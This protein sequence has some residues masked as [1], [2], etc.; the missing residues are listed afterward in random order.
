MRPGKSV[1]PACDVMSRNGIELNALK[2][3][4]VGE[5]APCKSISVCDHDFGDE[6]WLYNVLNDTILAK[7]G[8]PHYDSCNI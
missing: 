2:A 3:F 8:Q 5:E 6:D 4:S 7:S 1:K